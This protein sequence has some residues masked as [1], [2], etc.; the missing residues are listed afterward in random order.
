MQKNRIIRGAEIIIFLLGFSFCVAAVPT[1]GLVAYYPFNRNLENL[2]SQELPS[3]KNF[4]ASFVTDR[5][6]NN[7]AALY[8]SKDSTYIEFPDHD[9]YSIQTTGALTISVWVNPD[10][11]NFKTTDNSYV[12]WMGKGEPKQHEWTFRMYNQNSERPNRMSAYAFNLNGGLGSGSYVQ[13]SITAGEWIHFLAIYDTVQNIIRLYKNAVLKDSDPLYDETYQVKVGNGSAPLRLGTRSL[14]SFFKGKID[15]LRIYN[16]VLSE[17]EIADLYREI[18]MSSSSSELSSSSTPESSS[19]EVLSSST[20]ESS[21]ATT[22]LPTKNQNPIQI[23][24]SKRSIQI[25]GVEPGTPLILFDALGHVLNRQIAPQNTL[26]L[27]TSQ[28][29]FLRVGNTTYRLRAT[30]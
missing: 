26:Q 2:S 11:L 17:S 12:H 14:W 7:E 16:R 27:P 22:A 20:I 15:D 8:F 13:E 23:L 9:A 30:R 3:G 28:I 1:A 25:L 18:P 21:S 29:Y 6:G 24:V 10:T 4:G 19:S 5:F